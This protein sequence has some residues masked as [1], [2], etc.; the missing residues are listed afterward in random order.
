M[1]HYLTQPEEVDFVLMVMQQQGMD[2]DMFVQQQER[3][4]YGTAE[5]GIPPTMPSDSRIKEIS[6]T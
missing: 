2:L 6:L 1:G 4:R 5:Q 3:N